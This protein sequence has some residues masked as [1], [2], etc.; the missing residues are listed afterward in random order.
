MK[1]L[2]DATDP[3]MIIC[4][5]ALQRIFGD[6]KFKISAISQKISQH[7][8]PPQPIHL[9]H[10]VKVSGHSPAGKACYDVAVDV[11]VPL[12][13]EMN[14]FLANLERHKD[15]DMFDDTIRTAIKKIHEHRRRRA[16]FLGFSQSPVDFINTLIA[17]QSKDL[18]VVAGEASRNAERER[19]SDFYNQPWYLS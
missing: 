4:D 12:Q 5:P 19:R 18:K 10:R 15:I 1:K 13:K 17:S 9:E 14:A 6:E 16:F 7:L 8:L 11:P 3:S 2:Q